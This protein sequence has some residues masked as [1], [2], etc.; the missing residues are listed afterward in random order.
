M[1]N[2]Q[3][4]LI[5]ISS[6][7]IVSCESNTY[8]DI[9]V[10]TNPTY[11]ANIGPII[12]SSCTSCHSGNAQSPNLET[13]AEVKDATINGELICRI[14]QT[15]ACGRVMPQSGSMPKT[16]IAMF[17]LWQTQGCQN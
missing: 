16:T 17:L 6:I 15:Q 5:L 1:K 12:K 3:I 13:Y 8:S 4:L 11:S 9:A 7:F 14:D 2:I 10:V